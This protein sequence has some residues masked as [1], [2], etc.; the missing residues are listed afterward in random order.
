MNR[1]AWSIAAAFIW[2]L[3]AIELACACLLWLAR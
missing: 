3:A 1:E 2:R